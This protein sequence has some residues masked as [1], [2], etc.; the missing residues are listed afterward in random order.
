[1]KAGTVAKNVENALKGKEP[2]VV[3]G[4]PIDLLACATGRSRGVGRAGPIKMLSFMVWMAKGRTM[5]VELMKGYA[6]G[7][8]A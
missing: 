2:L 5:G 4:M 8:V 3:N 6:T 7:S 1:M